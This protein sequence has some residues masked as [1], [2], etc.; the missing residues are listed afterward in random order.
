MDI[1]ILQNIEGAKKARGLAVIIDVFRAFST[2]CYVVAQGAEKIIPVGDIEL[3]Y[4]LKK[5][6]PDFILMGERDGAIQ[7]GFDFGNS[8][9]EIRGVDFG[10]RTVVHTTANG[11]NGMA[12]AINAAEIIT[13]SFVNVQA[14]IEYIRSKDPENVSLVCTGTANETILDEDAMC[15]QYI[16]NALLGKPNDF[17]AI[18]EHLKTAGFAKHFFDPKVES[19][20]EGDFHL[21][22]ALDRFSFILKAE[23]YQ[24]GLVYLKRIEMS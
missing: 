17:G 7:P 24:D 19:H 21:C 14:V 16:K 20:P 6:N 2:A 8:P 4:K 3:A 11:T 10:G 15:A 13:G 1:E 22:I 18:V 12:N 9:F 23:P 5:E